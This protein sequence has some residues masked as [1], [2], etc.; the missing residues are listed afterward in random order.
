MEEK[1][2]I[3]IVNYESFFKHPNIEAQTRKNMINL[4]SNSIHFSF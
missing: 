3:L 2:V 4:S 1:S